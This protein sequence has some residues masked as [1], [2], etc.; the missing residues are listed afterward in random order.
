[1]PTPLA[2]RSREPLAH[3]FPEGVVRW[4][5]ESG[6]DGNRDKALIFPGAIPVWIVVIHGHGSHEDQLYTRPD[7]RAHWLPAL[8]ETGAGILTPNLRDNAWMSP[9]A[10]QD[11]HDLL[12][13]VRSLYGAT[14]FLFFSGS[15][16]GSANLYYAL[17]H[18][19]DVTALAAL[20]AA[21]DPARY[22]AWCR[23][24]PEQSIQRQIGTAIETAYGGPSEANPL[25]YADRAAGAR[26]FRLTMPVYLSHGSRDSLMPVEESRLLAHALRNQP[27]FRYQEIQEGNHDSPLFQPA[28]LLWMRS[29]LRG[30]GKRNQYNLA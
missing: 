16:G 26:A 23:T 22:A 10:T 25:P 5:Y 6:L 14:H 30:L 29:I 18:P 24:F 7:I 4:T 21:P 9:A 1:M 17:Q 2:I 20:G 27:A 12:D 19:E 8:R 3:P 13:A 28:P 15:M 11:L